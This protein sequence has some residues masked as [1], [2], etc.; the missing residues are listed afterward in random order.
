MFVRHEM[1]LVKLLVVGRAARATKVPAPYSSTRKER[2]ARLTFQFIRV[3]LCNLWLN[4]Y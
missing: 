1:G 2:A 4:S 3:H